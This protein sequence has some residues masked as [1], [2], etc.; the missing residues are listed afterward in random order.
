MAP[1]RLPLRGEIWF[2][3]IPT[4]PPEKGRRPVVVVSTNVRN[5]HLR[6]ATVLVVPLSTS[7]HKSEVATHLTLEPGETGLAELTIARAE[8]G[9]VIRKESLRPPRERLRT[10]SN[11]QVCKLAKLVAIAMSCA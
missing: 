3:E 2:T 8:D 10:L 1:N 11:L 5:S 6:A 4:D 9:T 7:V